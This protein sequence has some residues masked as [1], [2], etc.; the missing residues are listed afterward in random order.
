MP[1]LSLPMCLFCLFFHGACFAQSKLTFCVELSEYPPFNYLQK[2]DSATPN[3][4][5]YDIDIL[6]LVFEPENIEYEVVALPWRRCLKEVEN[7]LIDGAMSASLNG[8]RKHRYIPSKAYYALKPSYYYLETDFPNGLT[9]NKASELAHYKPVC[10]ISGFNYDNFGYHDI[11]EIFRIKDLYLLPKMLEQKRCRVF[12]A[13]SEVFAATLQ[14]RNLSHFDFALIEK[15][16]PNLPPEPFH[17]LVSRLSPHKEVILSLFNK[18][19]T[20]LEASGQLEQLLKY[21]SKMPG[22]LNHK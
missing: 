10:G 13:R 14:L 2:S 18:R 9:I 8:Q 11:K 15:V 5:G 22:L 7:G 12:L 4:V 6:K 17:M 20:N 3:I 16:I 1:K 21:H 19:I